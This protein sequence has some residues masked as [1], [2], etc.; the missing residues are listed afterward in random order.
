VNKSAN[1]NTEG[2]RLG[3]PR[4]E[5]TRK[6]VLAAAYELL[7]ES[8]FKN[9][10]VD[11][12]AEKS[13]V[14]K[15]TIYKWWLNKSAVVLDSFFDASE[16]ILQIPDTGSIEED[17]FMQLNNLATFIYSDKGKAIREFIAEGQ[18]DANM[19]N[20][21]RQRYFFPRRA[22]SAGILERAIIR[23]ELREDLDIEMAIDLIFSPLFYRLLIMDEHIDANYIRKML[24]SI[25]VALKT[26][27]AEP[28]PLAPS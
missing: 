24:S 16:L 21:Y 28:E 4:S 19:A 20:E 1:A 18:F 17:L 25:L 22:I 8:G 5:K 26:N 9:V 12:I 11:G 14:S 13:G 6:A 10:T 2:I 23:G 27:R 15:A 7:Q 3:R